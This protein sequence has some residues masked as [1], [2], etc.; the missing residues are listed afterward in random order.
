MRYRLLFRRRR[1]KKTTTKRLRRISSSSMPAQAGGVPWC[2]GRRGRTLRPRHEDRFRVDR[3]VHQDGDFTV[4]HVV[5]EA[6]RRRLTLTTCAL[7]GKRDW[8][9]WESLQARVPGAPLVAA[10]RDRP[11]RRAR[12][13]RTA[14]R[15]CSPSASEGRSLQDR[16]DAGERY[17]DVKLEQICKKGLGD[18]GLPPRAQPARLPLRPPSRRGLHLRSRHGHPDRGSGAPG[19][20]IDR[21][22]VEEGR[23]GYAPPELWRGDAGPATDLYAFAATLVAA[24]NGCDAAL[25]PRNDLEIDLAGRVPQAVPAAR[26]SWRICWRNRQKRASPPRPGIEMLRPTHRRE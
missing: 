4:T 6:T 15:T 24:A 19:S 21:G 2:C 10:P 12:R 3:V 14:A 13:G 16:M 7:K 25:L 26:P 18:P 11:L 5:E 23:D 9:A 22:E 1:K 17:T 20:R 8:S